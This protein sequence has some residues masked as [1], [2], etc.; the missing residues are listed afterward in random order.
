M[1]WG[2]GREDPVVQ[3]QCKSI[4]LP[5]SPPP[6]CWTCGVSIAQTRLADTTDGAKS[7]ELLGK[8]GFPSVPKGRTFARP[9]LRFESYNGMGHSSSPEEIEDLKKWLMEALK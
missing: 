2:H 6:T 3:Y 9:G 1:F 7:V 5:P 8:L 4:P